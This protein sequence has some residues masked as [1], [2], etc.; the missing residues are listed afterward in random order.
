MRGQLRAT[1]RVKPAD[2]ACRD[3]PQDGGFALIVVIWG[4]GLLSVIA[5]SFLI[6][7]NSQTRAARNMLDAAKAEMLADAG[8]RIAALK[9][10]ARQGPGAKTADKLPTDGTPYRCRLGESAVLT[11]VVSDEDGKIDLNA[12]GAPLLK[13]VLGSFVDDP[14]KVSSLTGAILDFRDSDDLV[15]LN[16]A[17][18]KD[19]EAAGL[20]HGP[21]NASFES[22][23]ELEQVLG[24][25]VPLYRSLLPFVT[26]HSQRNGIDPQVAPAGLLERLSARP[27]RVPA[28]RGEG[29][30]DRRHLA[31]ASTPFRLASSKRHFRVLAAIELPNGGRFV[32]DAVVELRRG[33]RP[34]FIFKRWIRGNW[35]S[36]VSGPA[37]NALRNCGKRG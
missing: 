1:A 12:A 27:G 21:K 15:Q 19:Y 18:T 26:V 16:G 30:I 20:P 22:V 9:L 2:A 36:A 10:I 5:V 11:L 25:P 34:P 35:P 28:S 31:A 13:A 6:T 17:E 4:I 24:L 37:D 32:R 7:V 33:A 8:V 23:E 14:D 29:R 3:T